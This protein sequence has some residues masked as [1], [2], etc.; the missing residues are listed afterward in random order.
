MSCEPNQTKPNQ[1]KPNQG[2]RKIKRWK[3]AG[4][5][6]TEHK[7]YLL[8]HASR[9]EWGRGQSQKCWPVEQHGWKG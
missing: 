3:N 6:E 5:H 2:G 9:T 8:T 7:K 4:K 1:A